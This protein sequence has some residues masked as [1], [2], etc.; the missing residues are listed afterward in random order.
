MCMNRKRSSVR[1]VPD[2]TIKS[3]FFQDRT[4]YFPAARATSK[5]TNFRSNT[6]YYI[7]N[8]EYTKSKLCLGL[9][10]TMESNSSL[11]EV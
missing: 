2:S 9:S 1:E 8:R 11:E 7:L 10:G 6:Y 4:S 5:K 3:R